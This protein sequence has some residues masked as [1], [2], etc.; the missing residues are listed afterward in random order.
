MLE[1]SPSPPS[2][3]VG[4]KRERIMPTLHPNEYF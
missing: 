4:V 3:F 1:I 2:E